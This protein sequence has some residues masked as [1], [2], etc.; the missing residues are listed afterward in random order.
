VKDDTSQ[1]SYLRTGELARMAGVSPN[2]LRH[3]E[4]LG[5]LVRPVRS[6]NG[7]REFP[8]SALDRVRLVQRALRLGFTLRELAR[9]LRIRDKGGAPCR[10]VRSLASGKLEEIESQLNQLTMLRDEL[11]SI[12]RDWDALLNGSA[13]SARAGLLESLGKGDYG[14]GERPPP[15][16]SHRRNLKRNE[17]ESDV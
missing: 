10:E 14:N 13:A 15:R 9:I 1:K 8:A 11:R 6:P 3:Y 16:R 7:Y 12:L 17:R 4:R 5:L 2:T